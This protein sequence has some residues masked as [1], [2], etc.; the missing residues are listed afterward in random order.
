MANRIVVGMSGGVDSSV[1]AYLL[2]QQG[3]DVV[4]VFMQNWQETDGQGVCTAADDY[5]DV[6]AVCQR[7]D[8][9][10][11][12]IN[13]SQKYW[14]RVFTY[15][16]EEYKKGRTPNPDVLCNREIKFAAFLQYALTLGAEAIATGH[17]CGVTYRRG[18]YRLLRAADGNKDQTYFLHR[19]DGRALSKVQFPLHNLKKP[20]VRALAERLAL[21]VAHKKDST[22]VCFI[23]ERNF[24]KFL[25]DYLPAQ[26][27]D[28]FTADGNWVGRHDGLM[29][30]TLGQRRGI[31][32]GDQGAGD[33]WFVVDK[34]L[35][36]N[37]L[38]VHRD[39]N[40]PLLFSTALVGE[41]LYF[42]DGSALR[43]PLRCAVKVRY[44]QPDQAAWLLPGENSSCHIEFDTPQRAV[45]PGQYA[46]VYQGDECLGGCVIQRACPL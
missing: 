10:Y 17:Y 30:Y 1:A 2:K 41:D 16:L 9:P 12:S 19:I 6:R 35:E 34:D 45:T 40:S 39:K 5:A 32:I 8:I 33:R 24:K 13:F 4:G 29:Y 14:D 18:A 27:G 38:I 11:Y 23:G 44:R 42:L 43:E 28:I 3:W 31:G 22:G 20:Q 15:F 25:Q 46:V 37:R 36:R 21:P 7:L 26:P